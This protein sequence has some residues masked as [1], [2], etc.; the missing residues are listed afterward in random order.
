MD[1]GSYALLSRLRVVILGDQ[2]CRRRGL[3]RMK[4]PAA[5]ATLVGDVAHALKIASEASGRN[6]E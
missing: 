6:T 4:R 5:L 1:G 2:I 3:T